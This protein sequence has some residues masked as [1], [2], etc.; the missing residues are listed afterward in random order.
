MKKSLCLL[1]LI[2]AAVSGISGCSTAV[3]VPEL[4]PVTGRVVRA[5]V[6]V[7]GGGLYFAPAAGE[8]RGLIHNASVGADGTFA[9]T[10]EVYGGTPPTRAGLPAG[11]YKVTYLPVN[12]GQK[13][14][15]D[16][17]VSEPITVEPG[18]APVILTLP[19]E[20]PVGKGTPR[21]DDPA[22]KA[23]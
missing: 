14:G 10:T 5:G 22:T 2:A 4:H 21:D 6:P 17:L 20:V 11:T 16:V 12:D 8:Q 3:T 19:D 9:A 18:L 7:K 13:S 15:L 1:P 23:R